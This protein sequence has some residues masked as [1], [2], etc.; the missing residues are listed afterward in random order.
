MAPDRDSPFS[1]QGEALD[2]LGS[3]EF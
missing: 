3:Q 2:P 1:R